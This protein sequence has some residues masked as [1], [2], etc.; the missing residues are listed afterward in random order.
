MLVDAPLRLYGRHLHRK[1]LDHPH[2]ITAAP[3]YVW[4]DSYKSGF[5]ISFEFTQ[6]DVTVVIRGGFDP[7]SS[8]ADGEYTPVKGVDTPCQH[9]T[10]WRSVSFEIFRGTATLPSGWIDEYGK[11]T[12]TLTINNDYDCTDIG[13][14]LELGHQYGDP[15]D[16]L[17]YIYR[18]V[19]R[20]IVAG[21]GG[22]VKITPPHA[23]GWES[24]IGNA[25]D[26]DCGDFADCTGTTPLIWDPF[27]GGGGGGTPPPPPPTPPPPPKQRYRKVNKCGGG[28]HGTWVMGGYASPGN[29]L[30]ADGECVVV[31]AESRLAISPPGPLLHGVSKVYNTCEECLNRAIYKLT[32]CQVS[33]EIVYTDSDL[34]AIADG[35][36]VGLWAGDC[37]IV[38]EVEDTGQ[39]LTP[40]VGMTEQDD[41]ND[42]D[43]PDPCTTCWSIDIPPTW[44]AASVSIDGTTTENPC[45]GVSGWKD[46]EYPYE[47]SGS[48]SDSPVCNPPNTQCAWYWNHPASQGQASISYDPVGKKYYG[49]VWARSEQYTNCYWYSDVAEIS[50]VTCNKDTGEIEGG[51]TVNGDA[52]LGCTGNAVVSL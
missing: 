3:A 6:T 29:V 39:T 43:C 26:A 21:G 11:A 41:C 46:G 8:G 33:T 12:S 37:W 48:C 20:V 45:Q 27:D 38:E 42:A 15:S 47:A 24:S 40:V 2:E 35:S 7:Y 9:S 44:G 13:K 30:L 4:T 52:T 36:G 5:W 14:V 17:N 23:S 16:P 18:P 50:G 32:S 25:F 22:T 51:F 34:S 10:F 49:Y 31:S 28:F 1:D 19:S